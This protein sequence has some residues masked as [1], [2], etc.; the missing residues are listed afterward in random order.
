MIYASRSERGK[1]EKNED[2]VFTPAAGDPALVIVADGMGGHNAGELASEIA[3]SAVVD[4]IRDGSRSLMNPIKSLN[5]AAKAANSAVYEYAAGDPDCRG[6][7]TTLVM[8]LLYDKKFV[9]ANVGDS[10][11]YH[12]NGKEL[13]QVTT[14][15]SLVAELV[16]AGYI[17][18]EEALHH[19]R[20]NVIT[21]ALG[22]RPSENVDIFENR[23]RRGDILLLCSDGFYEVLPEE[24][25]AQM[26]RESTNLQDT[27]NSFTQLAMANGSTDNISIVLVKNGGENDA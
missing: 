25:I 16:A 17:T 9:A 7:G 3:V 12:Y 6:M 26:L 14:D 5:E 4:C 15:H 22:T 8:A 20:R 24:K 18:R 27:C 10:R 23:W 1:R 2:N 11:L 21:R 13:S 19:P